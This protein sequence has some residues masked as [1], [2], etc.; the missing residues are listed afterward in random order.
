MQLL[1]PLE[2]PTI[3]LP[4]P[5]LLTVAQV[6]SQIRERLRQQAWFSFEDLL[7]VAVRRVEIVVTLWA[8]LELLKRRAITAEQHD[9]FGPIQIGRG[10]A[11][12]D[13]DL[14]TIETT[15]DASSE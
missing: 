3:P 14:A 6:A 4:A 1:L 2:P 15:E 5:K 8:V 9:I 12:L 11:L 10:P 13:V 7:A